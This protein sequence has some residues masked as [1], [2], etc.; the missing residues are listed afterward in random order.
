MNQEAFWAAV[1]SFD[2]DT[3]LRMPRTALSE[4]FGAEFA[5]MKDYPHDVGK[6]AVAQ[7]KAGRTVFYGH[8]KVSERAARRRLG[9][10]G[11]GGE[12]LERIC[13]YIREHDAFISHKL[14]EELRGVTNP[15]LRPITAAEVAETVRCMQ[16]RA[17]QGGWS[18]TR[19][20]VLRLL[21]LCLADAAAQSETA[22][23]NGVVVD[24][25]ERK[26]ARLEAVRRLLS[27]R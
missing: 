17:R 13:F 26:I 4:R 8:A 24:T 3:L 23:Q 16:E 18:P 2:A 19:E 12:S 14:P 25:R 21:R 10:I 7:P 5:D 9:Q 15:Y 20:T 11:L 6:P 22:V 1:E 27:E